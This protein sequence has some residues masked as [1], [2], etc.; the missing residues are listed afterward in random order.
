MIFKGH[1]PGCMVSFYLK[2]VLTEIMLILVL[3]MQSVSHSAEPSP[4]SRR[5]G[6]TG[7]TS[8]EEAEMDALMGCVDEEWS[9]QQ[10]LDA[11]KH[12]ADE[13]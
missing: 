8:Q 12:A 10:R 1:S 13:V 9:E 6:T 3:L 5:R 2:T 4:S 7:P 11:A